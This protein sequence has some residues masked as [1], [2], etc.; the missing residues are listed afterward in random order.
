MLKSGAIKD[1]PLWYDVYRKYP[2]DIEPI[3]DRPLP[4]QDPVPEIVYE[5]D[6]DRAKIAGFKYR[7]SAG[8]RRTRGRQTDQSQVSRIIDTVIE[9]TSVQDPKDSK[10]D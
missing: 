4:P 3:A 1:V 6:F 7:K 10:S 5:E 9:K 8:G 2:P